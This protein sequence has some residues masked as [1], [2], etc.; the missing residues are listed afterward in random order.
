MSERQKTL[1]LTLAARISDLSVLIEEMAGDG[2]T[3]DG[4]EETAHEDDTGRPE[5]TLDD[6]RRACKK[7]LDE[8]RRE[9]V[10]TTAE[11][12]GVKKVSDLPEDKFSSFLADLE[13]AR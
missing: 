4:P 12:Y 6:I 2:G 5:V 10:Q 1:L 9:A 7:C 8:D 13:A 11:K 3:R